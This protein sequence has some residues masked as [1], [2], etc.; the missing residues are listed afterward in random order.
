MLLV[1]FFRTQEISQLLS[2]SGCW[3]APSL[4]STA[5]IF[6]AWLYF[7]LSSRWVGASSVQGYSLT[8]SLWRENLANGKD[9]FQALWNI[10]LR[11]DNTRFFWRQCNYRNVRLAAPPNKKISF[12]RPLFE[13]GHNCTRLKEQLAHYVFNG[14]G[15]N[16]RKDLAIFVL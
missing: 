4:P 11:L 16:W 14:G 8:S 5:L 10:L 9:N 15:G 6:R 2:H 12:F 13:Q 7:L 1:A 3:L